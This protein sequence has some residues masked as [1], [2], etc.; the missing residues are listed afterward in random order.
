MRLERVR[1]LIVQARALIFDVDGTLA[2]TEEAHRQ[3]FNAAFVETGLD[4]CWGN[5]RY[6][7]LLRVTGG[8]ERIRA[9]A[10]LQG[11]EPPLLSNAEIDKLHLLKNR[12]YAKLVANGGCPLRPGVRALLAAARSRGQ[13]LAIA[14][15]TS[16]DNI[17]VL[18]TAALGEDW[19]QSFEA[20]VAGDEVQTK[21]PS[22]AV[23]LE[24]LSQL[25]LPASQCLAIEDSGNGLVAASG[26]GIPV[27][28]CAA[29]I[30]ETTVFPVRFLP[31][32]TLP[33]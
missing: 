30:S 14:T 26:A 21:K 1:A 22:P 33:K 31:S 9:F 17:G 32:M 4:W 8:K 7:E 19:A 5:V 15:T 20:I 16:R 27:L 13:H 24:V 6:K 29:L 3:A 12:L 23:Y 2:E 18:L 11:G 28:S 25:N 10:S